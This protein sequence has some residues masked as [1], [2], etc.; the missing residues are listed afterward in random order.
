MW[1]GMAW[2]SQP[3]PCD[4]WHA[5]QESIRPRSM[6]RIPYLGS[7]LKTEGTLEERLQVCGKGLPQMLYA[8]MLLLVPMGCLLALQPD[9]QLSPCS[10]S[11]PG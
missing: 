9:W 3:V 5:P 7:T 10:S 8:L 4:G 11:S 6:R 2:Q 1:H